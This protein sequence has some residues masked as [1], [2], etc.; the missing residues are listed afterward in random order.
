M[1]ALF[2]LVMVAIAVESVVGFGATVLTPEWAVILR[3]RLSMYE[4]LRGEAQ[5]AATPAG[6]DAFYASYVRFVEL[7]GNG[8]LGGARFSGR[9]PLL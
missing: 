8:G 2:A 7:M 9:K 5:A 4:T 1:I 3:E 6:H